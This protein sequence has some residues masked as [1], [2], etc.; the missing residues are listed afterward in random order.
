M[1]LPEKQADDPGHRTHRLRPS[2]GTQTRPS[3][4]RDRYV[5]RGRKTRHPDVS[6]GVLDNESGRCHR[7]GG[8]ESIRNAGVLFPGS[9][10]YASV[11]STG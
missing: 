10:G 5:A 3:D 1:I 7:R 2:S 6:V 11:D 8:G 4:R 9:G